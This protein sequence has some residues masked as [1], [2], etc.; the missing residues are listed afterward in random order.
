[1]RETPNLVAFVPDLD[2]GL[3]RCEEGLLEGAAV[4]AGDG[5]ARLPEG[6]S[7]YLVRM[8]L[9]TGTTLIRQN[10]PAEDVFVLESGR[11]SVE[12]VT[13]EGTRMRVSTIEPGVVVGEVAHY[14]GVPRTADVI[15][16]SPSVVL[17]LSDASMERLEAQ[18]PALAANVHRWL[19][20]TLAERL[21]ETTRAFD[22]LLD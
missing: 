1:V 4:A 22:E 18:D 8:E 6:L 3:Q 17:R 19:A 13:I 21:S 9:E 10:D 12:M 16:E 15:A 5:S 20:T 14:A 11:L 7:A 2:R